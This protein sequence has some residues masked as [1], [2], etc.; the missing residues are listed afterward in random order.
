MWW[1][2]KIVQVMLLG[3]IS[4]IL[5]LYMPLVKLLSDGIIATA[6]TQTEQLSIK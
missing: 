2:E 4:W 6:R 5:Y 1:I 3:F